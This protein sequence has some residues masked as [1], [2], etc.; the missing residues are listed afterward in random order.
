MTLHAFPS[1]NQLYQHILSRRGRRAIFSTI[2]RQK[3]PL[4][5][6]SPIRVGQLIKQP[7]LSRSPSRVQK[8][9]IKGGSKAI[10]SQN[11]KVQGYYAWEKK[12]RA[13]E[14]DLA[15]CMASFL[16]CEER[17]TKKRRKLKL[18]LSG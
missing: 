16:F 2:P 17:S 13:R 9:H 10:Q 4:L 8:L 12:K 7:L 18:H 14:G 11:G 15:P 5:P 6:R 3:A 1:I